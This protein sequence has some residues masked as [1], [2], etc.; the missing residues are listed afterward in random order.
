MGEFVRYFRDTDP[1]PFFIKKKI[2]QDFIHK[3]IAG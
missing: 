1:L 2:F 3:I